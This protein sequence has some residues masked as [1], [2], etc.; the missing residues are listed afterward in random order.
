MAEGQNGYT[1]QPDNALNYSIGFPAGLS[2]PDWFHQF[3][4][5]DI[6]VSE[7]FSNLAT[8]VPIIIVVSTTLGL[9][10]NRF[11]RSDY[12]STGCLAVAT[13]V[14]FA[15]VQLV[16]DIGWPRT[17][18]IMLIPPGWIDIPTYLAFYLTLPIV[19]SLKG[20]RVNAV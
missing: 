20:Q 6:L 3:A 16:P 13:A 19:V 9:G 5:E 7:F 10:L 12:L 1:V 8:T 11:I 2:Y 15:F 17:I 18:S 4:E 14:L